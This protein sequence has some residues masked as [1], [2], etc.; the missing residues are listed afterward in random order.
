MVDRVFYD[1]LPVAGVRTYEHGIVE[2]TSVWI[3]CHGLVVVRD[4]FRGVLVMV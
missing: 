1:F 2:E 3:W 4:C